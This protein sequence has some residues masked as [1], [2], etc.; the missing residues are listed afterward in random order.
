MLE[1]DALMEALRAAGINTEEGLAYCAEDPEFYEEMLREYVNESEDRLA[2]LRRCREEQDLPS[3]GICAHSMKSTSRMIGA[4]EFVAFALEMEQ[5]G[6]NA[7]GD[8]IAAKHDAFLGEY[9][10]LIGKLRAALG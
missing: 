8:A 3:Y 7:D 4:G 10:A 9:T 1:I 6:K 2:E 5:A